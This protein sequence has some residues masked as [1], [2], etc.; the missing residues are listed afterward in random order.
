MQ[1]VRSSYLA[2]E[3][4]GCYVLVP[5]CVACLLTGLIM[6]LGITWGL[7]RHYWVVIKLVITVV[8]GVISGPLELSA[9]LHGRREKFRRLGRANR[10]YLT[11]TG[12]TNFANHSGEF[13]IRP[14]PTTGNRLTPIAGC[15]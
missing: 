11:K 3:L 5:L 1:L 9:I 7:F 8:S 6:S 14:S 10:K 13:G 4:I 12:G 2:M 15:E